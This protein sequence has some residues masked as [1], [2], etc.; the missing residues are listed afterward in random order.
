MIKVGV[1]MQKWEHPLNE[2]LK[3]NLIVA[4][5]NKGE[6]FELTREGWALADTL[7]DDL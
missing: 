7:P 3:L 5:D 4:R 2:L 6:V 1:I